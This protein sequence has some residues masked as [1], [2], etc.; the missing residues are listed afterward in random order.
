[1]KKIRGVILA[2]IMIGGLGQ[3]VIGADL[4]KEMRAQNKEIVRLVV[5]ETRK[6][7][8]QTIDKYTKFVDI[9]NNGLTLIYTF[10]IN[11]GAKSD[12]AIIREDEARMKKTITKGVCQSSKRF[13]DAQIN[14][15]Y[16][17]KSAKTDKKLFQFDF[18]KAK[19]VGIS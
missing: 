13:L 12:E 8:P 6:L 10:E 17:Y 2:L 4:S 15:T 9:K 19:C 3:S 14:I 5:K 1:M 7:L 18:T 16:I 11:T